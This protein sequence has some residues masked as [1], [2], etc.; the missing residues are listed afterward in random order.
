[1]SAP[2]TTVVDSSRQVALL[3]HG[4]AEPDRAWMLEQLGAS[5]GQALQPLLTELR[6]L[7]IPADPALTAQALQA[8]VQRRTAAERPPAAV[9]AEAR[10]AQ[11][12]QALAGE[13][14]GLLAVL[15]AAGE[16]PWRHV[17]LASLEPARAR[18]LNE[19]LET[20]RGGPALQQALLR[21]VAE[22]LDAQ[23]PLPLAVTV[24]GVPRTNPNW[25]KYLSRVPGWRTRAAVRGG[26]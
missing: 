9:I 5:Q 22:R 23:S 19:V 10:A 4:L 15:L 6:E 12:Q 8:H 18:A 3:L 26:A 20:H 11:M 7:G 17:F 14:V 16:W 21:A 25:A 24:P 2:H 1:M 13:S